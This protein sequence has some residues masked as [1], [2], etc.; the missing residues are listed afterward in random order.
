MRMK[1]FIAILFFAVN[2]H[3]QDSAQTNAERYAS[4]P[5]VYALAWQRLG[6]AVV[7]REKEAEVKGK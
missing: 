3:G 4:S 7:A 2:A 1:I 6:K 5:R